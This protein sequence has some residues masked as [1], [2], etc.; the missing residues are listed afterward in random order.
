MRKTLG[1]MIVVMLTMLMVS[2]TG[3]PAS[4]QTPSQAVSAAAQVAARNGVTTFISVV[5]RSNGAVLAHTGNSGA[6]V[7][8]ESIMKLFLAGYYLL[9]YGG[10]RATPQSVKDRLAYMLKYSDDDTA[11]SLFTDSAIP[12]VAAR[13][14]LG[15]TIN[16]TDRSGHWGAARITA[17]DMT[18]FLYRAGKD[19]A[20]GPWLIPALANT[21]RTGSGA[22]AGFSQY[23]GLNALGG[24]HG[25]KQGW[26][27]DSFWTDPHCA[28]HS[29]G[30]TD[31]YF[32]A[33][34]QL[35]GGYPDPMRSTATNS[36]RTI[37]QSRTALVDG[38]FICDSSRRYVYRLAGGAPIYVS[39]WNVFG[40]AH[41]CRPMSPTEIGRLRVY[42]AE[43]TFLRDPISGA[44]YRVAGGAPVYVS[45]WGAFGGSHRTIDIDPA[46][47]RRA[48]SGGVYNH[49]R[50]LPA[51]GTFLRGTRTGAVF[52]VAGGAPVYVSSWG[53]FGRAQPTIDVDLA[54]LDRAGSGGVYNHLRYRPADGTFLR[55]PTT[56]S[57]FRVA[58]G[59]PLYVT[60]WTVF[61]GTKPTV[62]VDPA[63]VNRASNVHYYD[64]LLYYPQNGTFVRG[65]PGNAVYR[66]SSGKP[67]YVPSWAAYGGPQPATQITQTT[68]DRAGSGGYF[69]HLVR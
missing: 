9:L 11:S 62:G 5:D 30:Y 14:G 53:A 47:V 20:V 43:G 37:Q 36:A 52:R 42:P 46:A 69:N 34:L 61:G 24:V 25:S 54:A 21:A 15:S 57:V 22:D 65:Q 67:T 29:V 55:L 58:G 19:S 7:G 35:S 48:G 18:R 33:V 28:V 26:G 59:A 49:L 63:A 27:C 1:V 13:Y 3:A 44:V 12:T 6:Q 10:Y 56:G 23:F 2:A 64:H 39:S 4:A 68:I 8:S 51:D 32:V 50:Y 31:R 41:P 40:G 60:A 66:I 17:D 45:T 38:D 16:A